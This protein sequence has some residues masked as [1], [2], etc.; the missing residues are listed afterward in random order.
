MNLYYNKLDPGKPK[1]LFNEELYKNVTV[2]MN[3]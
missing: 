3:F 2:I 1:K